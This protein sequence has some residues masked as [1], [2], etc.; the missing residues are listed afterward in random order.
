MQRNAEADETKEEEMVM[1]CLATEE[2]DA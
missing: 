2:V 1:F